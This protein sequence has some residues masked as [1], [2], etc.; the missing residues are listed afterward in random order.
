MK[1]RHTNLRS[2]NPWRGPL[3]SLARATVSSRHL[4]WKLDF[5]KHSLLTNSQSIKIEAPFAP[6][7]IFKGETF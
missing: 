6:W 2:P 1:Q 7:A 5:V 3:C 4:E